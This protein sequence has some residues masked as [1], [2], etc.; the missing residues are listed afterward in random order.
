MS[1]STK[2]QK[3]AIQSL[4]L[5]R[6][7]LG[8]GFTKSD[9]GKRNIFNDEI[10]TQEF[11]DIVWK[12]NFEVDEYYYNWA[13]DAFDYFC[14]EIEDCKDID[15]AIQ[16]IEDCE[17]E[18]LSGEWYTSNLTEWLNSANKRVY[19]L[20]EAME[21]YGSTDGFEVLS[22]AYGI[23]QREVYE[24]TRDIVLDII[25]VIKST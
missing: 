5:L 14:S 11:I 25:Q 12:H 2:Q 15:R 8:N 22:T 4:E 21:Q 20:T 17:F 10:I 16:I 23:E 3:L 1:K 18:S 24:M 19:Y 13:R 6:T 7:I 9:D